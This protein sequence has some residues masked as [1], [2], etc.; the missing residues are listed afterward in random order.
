MIYLLASNV[1]SKRK[2]EGPSL[3]WSS[4]KSA[5]TDE[6]AL[7]VNFEERDK[8][9][10]EEG[11]GDKGPVPLLAI[12]NPDQ[13]HNSPEDCHDLQWCVVTDFVNG[14]N[15]ERDGASRSSD[16]NQTKKMLT[17]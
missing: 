2:E 16:R 15:T 8:D 7:A 17:C 4:D 14:G 10:G 13:F 1:S 5:I 11:G 9:G 12:V 6:S 3:R